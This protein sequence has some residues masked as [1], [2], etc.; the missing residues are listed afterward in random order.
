[1]LKWYLN[2]QC[3]LGS[4]YM[5][6]SLS[7]HVNYKTWSNRTRTV[8]SVQE[9]SI[10]KLYI[11]AKWHHL[12]HSQYPSWLYPTFCCLFCLPLEHWAADFRK[13]RDSFPEVRL[14]VL[15]SASLRHGLDYFCY[16]CH[17]T[18]IYTVAHYLL[19]FGFHTPLC[20][21]VVPFVTIG[22]VFDYLEELKQL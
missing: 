16:T 2:K 12:S 22:L 13:L 21:I 7:W 10:P 14:T 11:A 19:T 20:E 17:F 1:M 3:I 9:V 6:C 4:V 15:S 18:F 5:V 8:C